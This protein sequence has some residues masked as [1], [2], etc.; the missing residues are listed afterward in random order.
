M[1]L[2]TFA[3]QNYHQSFNPEPNSLDIK[4]EKKRHTHGIEYLS[5]VYSPS[6]S[7]LSG[8]LTRCKV[9]LS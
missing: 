7:F 4:E 3:P 9:D 8:A 5:F 2:S 1:T 6:P